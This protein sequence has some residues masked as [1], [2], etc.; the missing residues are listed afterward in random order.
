MSIKTVRR[1][2]VTA[3]KK[4]LSKSLIIV[5][6]E[7]GAHHVSSQDE[8]LEALGYK[9]AEL[10]TRENAKGV[11]QLT[12]RIGTGYSFHAYL[13]LDKAKEKL[14]ESLF[15]GGKFKH[16]VIDVLITES[17]IDAFEEGDELTISRF[18]SLCYQQVMSNFNQAAEVC[19][20]VNFA[21]G[22]EQPFYLKLSMFG[23]D[24]C[25][26]LADR[27]DKDISDLDCDDAFEEYESENDLDTYFFLKHF[28]EQYSLEHA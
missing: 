12:M 26:G 18:E 6:F 16:K 15:L 17:S 10:T 13:D 23:D 7:S 24:S 27:I 8:F 20:L 25:L 19:V 22:H 21:N 1:T 28:K 3:I 5:R 11:Y 2:N 9:T 4:I 14:P